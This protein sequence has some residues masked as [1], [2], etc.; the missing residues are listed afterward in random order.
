MLAGNFYVSCSHKGSGNA[1]GPFY[2]P[3]EGSWRESLKCLHCTVAKYVLFCFFI[4]ESGPVCGMAKD[5]EV[6]VKMAKIIGLPLTG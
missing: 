3:G 5:R 4:K 6:I 1:F 2:A